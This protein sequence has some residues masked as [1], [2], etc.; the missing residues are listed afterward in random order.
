MVT[1]INFGTDGWR[2]L[3][4]DEFTFAN[5]ARCTWGLC[6]YL[7]DA[8]KADNGLIVGYDTRF[9]SSEFAQTVAGVCAHQGIKVRLCTEAAPTP[10]VSYNVLR[11]EADGAVII[12]SSHNPA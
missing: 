11:H 12:T 10:V 6:D 5:V 7:K 8:S 9:L 3:I 4:A 1:D 2:A